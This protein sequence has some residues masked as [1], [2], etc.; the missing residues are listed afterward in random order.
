MQSSTRI[1]NWD[2]AR[3]E[4]KKNGGDL[5]SIANQATLDFLV[6]NI[7]TTTYTWIGAE[8]KSGVWSWADGTPW[9]EFTNWAAGQPQENVVVVINKQFFWYDDPKTF[10]HYYLCEY[11]FF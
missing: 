8:K 5:A 1:A 9:T 2:D 3:A 11:Q 7:K 4:C 6:D 10:D